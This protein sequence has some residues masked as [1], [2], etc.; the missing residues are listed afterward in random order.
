LNIILKRK[1][2]GI[3][4]TFVATTGTPDNHGING[5]VNFKTKEFN[6]FLNS[7]LQL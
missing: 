7:R 1:N 6:L 4:G 3:N 5:T 2:Q